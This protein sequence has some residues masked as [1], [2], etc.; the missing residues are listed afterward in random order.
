MAK[1]KHIQLK[2]VDR[3]KAADFYEKVFGFTRT[4]E[5]Q[6]RGDHSTVH[7][8]DGTIDLAMAQYYDD[9]S[10]EAKMHGEGPCIGHFGIEVEDVEACLKELEKRGCEILTPEGALPVKFKIPGAGGV[11]EIGPPGFFKHPRDPKFGDVA[12]L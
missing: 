7:L 6:I 11:V 1:I 8:E 4:S 5:R 2:V 12:T 9:G 3:H 10:K